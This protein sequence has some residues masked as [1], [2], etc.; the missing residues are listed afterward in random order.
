VTNE[1]FQESIND[2][3]RDLLPG[4]GSQPPAVDLNISGPPLERVFAV[5]PDLESV[6]TM[7]LERFEESGECEAKRLIG[8]LSE[9]ELRSLLTVL[10]GAYFLLPQVREALGYS[11][12]QALTLT[13][14]GFGAE[15]LVVAQMRQAKRYRI[16]PDVESVPSMAVDPIPE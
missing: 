3:A 7:I 1:K 5:R 14:G 10:C 13:R 11:G 4:N 6:V 16:P 15:E 8:S 9:S 2:L 12:Q